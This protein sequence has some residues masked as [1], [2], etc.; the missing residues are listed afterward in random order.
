MKDLLLNTTGDLIISNNDLV[1]GD[2]NM[3][4][5]EVLIISQPC[6]F[7][8]SP[9]VG[10]GAEDFLNGED[11]TLLPVVTREQFIRDGQ[12]V[13]SIG[14]NSQTGDLTYDANYNN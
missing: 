11:D 3:Q 2:S 8:E 9:D 14:Y 4:H 13:K 1:I 6:S 7:K 10:I 12:V 5:Q